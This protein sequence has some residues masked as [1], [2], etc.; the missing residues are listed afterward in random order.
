[1]AIET[2]KF[3]RSALFVLAEHEQPLLRE[4]TD[5]GGRHRS[6]FLVTSF[7]HYHYLKIYFV[8]SFGICRSRSLLFVDHKVRK[9]W[10]TNSDYYD[11]PRSFWLT[12]AETYKTTT[13]PLFNL[14]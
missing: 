6:I 12:R 3:I 4:T 5:Q 8:E 7:V 13:V 1:M 14:S 9:L 10:L 11:I 2:E